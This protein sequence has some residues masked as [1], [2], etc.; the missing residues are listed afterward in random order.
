MRLASVPLYAYNEL[1]SEAQHVAATELAYRAYDEITPDDEH[2]AA[3]FV[4]LRNEAHKSLLTD[5]LEQYMADGQLLPVQ[6]KD[7]S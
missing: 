1:S 3:T 7:L 5:P 6:E 2:F 4:Q